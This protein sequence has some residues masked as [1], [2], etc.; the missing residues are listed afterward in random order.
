MT[1]WG[2]LLYS[3]VGRDQQ[4]RRACCLYLQSR[5][6]TKPCQL[7]NRLYGITSHKTVILF[8]T[9]QNTD[10]TKIVSINTVI[11]NI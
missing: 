11:R 7:L 3:F 8:T 10:I 9:M 5:R 2:L 1:F 6:V 4:L